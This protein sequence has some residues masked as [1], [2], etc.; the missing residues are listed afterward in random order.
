MGH[1]FGNVYQRD[2]GGIITTWQLSTA[3]A[4]NSLSHE[5]TE[6]VIY[7]IYSPFMF[8]VKTSILLLYI[9][10]FEQSGVSP[11][12]TRTVWAVILVIFAYHLAIFFP[13]I[14]N[15]SPRGKRWNPKLEGTCVN[16]WALA[17]SSAVINIITDLLILVLP[18][19]P[20]WRLQLR[21]KQKI[22]VLG[23]FATG[24][25]YGNV[26]SSFSCP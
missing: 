9:R 22:T 25:L 21:K 15:C 7:S 8:F 19:G 5:Q 3:I 10:L 17:I 18:I 24:S 13:P 6:I 12:F 1:S 16:L 14:F 11:T 23:I 2:K 4:V 26:L 20:V